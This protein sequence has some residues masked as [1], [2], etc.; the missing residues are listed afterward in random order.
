MKQT[1]S[2]RF[3]ATLIFS[4]IFVVVIS[5]GAVGF[6]WVSDFNRET[7]DI[8]DRWLKN[9][10]YLGDLANY[11]SDLRAAESEYLLTQAEPRL[12]TLKQEIKILNETISQAQHNYEKVP[13]DP[14]ET[15]QYGVFLK[16]WSLYRNLSDTVFSATTGSQ[17][18]EAIAIYLSS[19]RRAFA[20]VS[21]ILEKMTDHNNLEAKQAS[22]RASDTI[23]QARFFGALTIAITAAAV[24]GTLAFI[25]RSLTVPLVELADCMH[26]LSRGDMDITIWSISRTDEL[27][28]MAQAVIIFQNNAIELKATQ[29][30]LAHQATM[31]EEQL[32]HEQRLSQQHRNFISMASHEFRTP[33]TIV[34]GHAQRLINAIE[35][36]SRDAVTDRARKIRIAVKRMKVMI[37]NLLETSK[38]IDVDPKLYFYPS[39]FDLRTLLHEVC[40]VHREISPK[41]VL[42]EDLKQEAVNI[43]GDRKFLFLAFSNLITNALKYSYDE[44]P[45][46]VQLIREQGAVVVT[47]QDHG[48]GIPRSDIDQLF[49]RYYRGANVSGIVGSGIGLY[50]VKVVTDLHGGSVK[51]ESSENQGSCFSVTLPIA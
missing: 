28:E 1:Q 21:D 41:A 30:K 2:I 35:P 50:L 36:L 31:L 4:L 51:V 18:T 40:S 20:D 46:I 16:E 7:S 15:G 26:R 25:T 5:L 8:R 48:I 38:M 9:T 3:R 33:M 47:V 45:I 23:Q 34:D 29:R 13:H 11:T 32:A 24:L 19:S 10:R 42:I 6:A 49:E 12:A 17:K 27:G 14:W 22:D 39:D 43:F 44:K 37:D